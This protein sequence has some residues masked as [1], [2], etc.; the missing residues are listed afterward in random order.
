MEFVVFLL[1][2]VGV[3]FIQALRGQRARER[4]LIQHLEDQ[5]GQVPDREYEDGD[6]RKIARYYARCQTKEPHRLHLDDITWNDLGMDEIFMLLNHT[7][8][9]VGEETLYRMLRMPETDETILAER[10]R[11]AK[12]FAADPELRLTLERA[13]HEI[14]RGRRLAFSD[15]IDLLS[16]QTPQSNTVHYLGLAALAVSVGLMAILPY[17]GGLMLIVVIAFQIIT[18]YRYKAQ[19]E[20]LFV[21]VANVVRLQLCAKEISKITGTQEIQT[22]QASLRQLAAELEPICRKSMVITMG[23]AMGGSPLD[24]LADYGKMLLHVD[25]IA[26]QQIVAKIRQ[27][28]S[29]VWQTMDTL[30]Q[31]ECS[32]AIA[33]FRQCLG[34]WCEP[35]LWT[36][37]A[38]EH[39]SGTTYA[40]LSLHGEGLYHP[41]VDRVVP[42][43]IQA[44]RSQLITGSNASGKSTFLK[45]VGLSAV[46]AQTVY[47]VP[48]RSYQAP[49]YQIYSSM[50][51]KDNLIRGES[52]YM[53][54]IRSLKRILDRGHDTLPVLCFVD[55]VL[56][57]TNTV[58]RIAAST[59]ILKSM[60]QMNI[61]CFAATHDGELTYLLEDQFEN[62]HFSETITEGDVLFTYRLHPGRAEGRNAL[63]LLG[64]M[65]YD[66]KVLQQAR[67][68][69]ERFD[70]TGTWS[71]YDEG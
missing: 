37:E 16:Q 62:G 45:T 67:D 36:Y 9:S 40:N 50:A 57:G 51:L 30:G 3:L 53:V 39:V 27:K 52:Y 24:L 68:M 31:L 44:D 35:E 54:E 38:G 7:Q 34:Q 10:D 33:S 55:E 6:L 69:A 46:L 8:S 21:C 13:F 17:Y 11:L 25:L 49:F 48:G 58:E 12:V 1:V 4:R 14:G 23:K 64:L 43:S 32:I 59:Q 5:W 22:Y 66:E 60:T 18:Y 56:R 65:G 42:N 61:L 26:Y 41:L 29:V 71:I 63:Q 20:D 70:R 15:Y 2:I 28:E 19:I 47:T